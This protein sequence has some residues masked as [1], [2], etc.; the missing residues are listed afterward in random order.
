MTKNSKEC[1]VYFLIEPEHFKIGLSVSVADRAKKVTPELIKEKSW[2]VFFN[3]PIEAKKCE[4]ALHR[5]FHKKRLPAINRDGGTELF[6]LS[7]LEEV[8]SFVLENKAHLGYSRILRSPELFPILQTSQL[9]RDE[10]VEKKKLL[11]EKKAVERARKIAETDRRR[12][13][14]IEIFNKL[15]NNGCIL[16]VSD[17]IMHY[18]SLY[19]PILYCAI[20]TP[21]EEAWAA[22]LYKN[23]LYDDDYT[24]LWV[25]NSHDYPEGK[26]PTD[27]SDSIEYIFGKKE[28]YALHF[29][30][31]H[32]GYPVNQDPFAAAY[33]SFA[34]STLMITPSLEGDKFECINCTS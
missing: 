9:E 4:G 13:L 12:I 34:E 32:S 20:S 23:A 2:A 25:I 17:K 7:C 14:F 11:E 22:D 8:E 29:F 16:G 28:V 19:A 3:S 15:N 21:Q 31:I 24:A 26:M 27:H 1:A 10:R 33:S 30:G 18:S 5:I 6:D